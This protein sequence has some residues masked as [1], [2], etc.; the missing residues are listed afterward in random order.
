VCIALVFNNAHSVH[1]ASLHKIYLY[2]CVNWECLTSIVEHS[3]F[4]SLEQW[5]Q[6]W[7]VILVVPLSQLQPPHW[8]SSAKY[9]DAT[10][11]SSFPILAIDKVLQVESFFNWDTINYTV[12]CILHNKLVCRSGNWLRCQLSRHACMFVQT[13]EN[14]LLVKTGLTQ[15]TIL[16]RHACMFVQT[17]ED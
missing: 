3:N 5:L 1:R 14:W 4:G 13:N 8:R 9:E 7:E 10:L 12:A 2:W 17:T 11:W 6:P 15:A 16:S